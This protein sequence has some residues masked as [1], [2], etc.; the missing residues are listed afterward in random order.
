V[1]GFGES[2][3]G[4]VY[5]TSDR[6]GVYVYDSASGA[7]LD[8][9]TPT[10]TMGSASGTGLSN[11]DVRAARFDAAGIGWFGLTA[12]GVDR[13]DGRGTDDHA[14]DRW[15]NYTTG[16]P[17]QSVRALAVLDTGTVYVGTL[18]GMAVLTHGVT[19]NARKNAINAVIGIVPVRDL[20]NDPRGVVWIATASGLARVDHKNGDVERFTSADGLVDNDVQGVAWDEAR[21]ILWVATAHGV[22]EVH[23]QNGGAPAFNDGAFVYP[24]PARPGGTGLRISGLSGA[25]TGEIR[26]VTGTLV[27]RFHAD[28]VSSGIWD[29]RDT[30][31]APAAPGIYMIVLRDG[32]RTRVLRAAVT[33]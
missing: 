23:P 8:S 24:V 15:S 26:D 20:A 21:G 12:A 31:G 33:R 13:W 11:L 9:L 6:N 1:L 3:S 19:D 29:L 25:V 32:G 10:N 27:R 18:N 22:S 28:P 14:D 16:F 7:L 30:S 4:R 2:P 17:S 5:A